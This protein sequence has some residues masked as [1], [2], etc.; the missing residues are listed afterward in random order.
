MNKCYEGLEGICMMFDK[1]YDIMVLKRVAFQ[2]LKGEYEGDEEEHC[3][4]DVE[5]RRTLKT[6]YFKIYQL[7]LDSECTKEFINYE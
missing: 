1:D 7:F 5:N 3:F 2:K 6:I 4:N